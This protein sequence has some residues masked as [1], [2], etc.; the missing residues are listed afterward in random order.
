M[1]ILIISQYFWPESF[2]IN[3]LALALKQRGHN[4]EVLTGMPNYPGGKLYPGYGFFT[5]ARESF[6]GIPVVR[7]PLLSRGAH[8]NWR[9]ALNYAC[10]ALSASVLGPLRC[11]KRYDVIFVYEPSP[12]TVAIPGIVFR[13]LKQA[14]MFLWVQDLWPESLTATGAV[15][16]RIILRL[17]HWLVRFIYRR[18][19]RVLVSSE[20]FIAHVLASGI[21]D[22]RVAYLPNWAESLYRP[23]ATA[24]ASVQ[25]ELPTGFN[26]IFAGNIGSAQSFETIISAAERLKDRRDIHWVILGEGNMKSWVA[27]Q[28][29]RRG[30][31]RQFHLLGS[32][33]TDTMPDY[34]AA[35][36][37]LLVTLRADPVFALTVPSKIQSYLACG[38]PI[39]AALNGEGAS[40][41]TKSEA[42]VSCAAEDP[43]KLATAVLTLYEMSEAQRLTMG[44]NA[45]AYFESNF[46]RDMLLDRLE[47]WMLDTAGTESCAF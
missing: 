39:I 6:E 44:V 38:K 45:R 37:A 12:I 26:V 46:E 21:E 7:V 9:L 5:P 11:R 30:L 43:D 33:P 35:A 10:F 42:G 24:S 13:M 27:E 17:V 4:V 2:R 25:S 3:D 47:Q 15:N 34:F 31:E 29:R 1:K 32:R 36:G 18:C 14:P 16:S 8:K 40:I 19:D 22:K 28:A 20:G 41:I 23:L